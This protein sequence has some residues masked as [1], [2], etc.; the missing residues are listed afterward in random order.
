MTLK[1]NSEKTNNQHK[2]SG[3]HWQT[4]KIH[5]IEGKNIK[6]TD[7]VLNGSLIQQ[8]RNTLPPYQSI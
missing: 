4:S 2:T 8:S 5:I 1:W 7:R 3:N 6:A